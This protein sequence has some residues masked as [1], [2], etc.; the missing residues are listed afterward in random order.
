MT[1]PPQPLTV[2]AMRELLLQLREEPAQLPVVT[3]WDPRGESGAAITA[4]AAEGHSCL[5]CGAPA[6]FALV[7]DYH[8]HGPRWLDFC[9][10]CLV[11]AGRAN[12]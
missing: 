6:R 10:G 11:S 12:S 3:L 8:W 5:G 4:R 9:L 2:P 1:A 7:G